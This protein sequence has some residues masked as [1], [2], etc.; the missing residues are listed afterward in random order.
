MMFEAVNHRLR[1]FEDQDVAA[2][3]LILPRLTVDI[4]TDLTVD[5]KLE[6]TFR[7]IVVGASFDVDTKT[8]ELVRTHK[9]RILDTEVECL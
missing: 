5:E 2:S 4:P 8:G 6:V 1:R 9:I 3:R 7:A